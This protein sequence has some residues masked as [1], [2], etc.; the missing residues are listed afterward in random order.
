MALLIQA[1]LNWSSVLH[2]TM[3]AEDGSVLLTRFYAEGSFQRI[4]ESFSGY[5]SILPNFVGW[6]VCCLPTTWIPRSMV[7]ASLVL[8][9]FGICLFVAAALGGAARRLVVFAALWMSSLAI[10]S[11]ALSACVMYSRVSFLLMLAAACWT[12]RH[13][14]V[15]PVVTAMA[16]LCIWSHPLSIVVVG[17]MMSAWMV[18]RARINMGFWISALVSVLLY[19]CFGLDRGNDVDV[20]WR[21][22]DCFSYIG[23]RGGIE[24]IVPTA[25]KSYWYSPAPAVH[26][27]IG[28]GMCIAWTAWIIIAKRRRMRNE[29]VELS[30][31]GWDL[32]IA[33][34]IPLCALT[35]R[36]HT[37]GP[38]DEWGQRYIFTTRGLVL[39]VVAIA[40]LGRATRASR[41]RLT[42]VHAV[43]IA[44]ALMLGYANRV[45]YRVEREDAERITT[46]MKIL[47]TEELSHAGERRAVRAFLER[48][49]WDIR[50]G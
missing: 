26:G 47:D 3:H 1:V 45:Y 44:Y 41:K 49:D 48:G 15:R 11:Y 6:L 9:A 2:P 28:V 30:A 31:S 21:P 24:L 16:H 10:G 35:A 19:V 43:M 17:V 32:L 36:P 29:T 46:F 27:A 50:I 8:H 7:L 23:V 42:S 39:L 12:A 25:L 40:A 34:A 18:R 38:A 20:A 5:K 37:M 4:W 22:L 33:V 13:A 14:T